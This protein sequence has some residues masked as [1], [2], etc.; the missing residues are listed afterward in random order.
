MGSECGRVSLARDPPEHGDPV[1]CRTH[2][3][4]LG[5]HGKRLHANETV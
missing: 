2:I 5:A 1:T 4:P 3:T